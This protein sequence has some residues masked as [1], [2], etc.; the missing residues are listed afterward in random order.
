MT[1]VQYLNFV[2]SEDASMQSTQQIMS[3]SDHTII[4]LSNAA[5]HQQVC[6]NERRPGCQHN[7]DLLDL[8][9]MKC[10]VKSKQYFETFRAN[11]D[12][13][14]WCMA[15]MELHILMKHLIDLVRKPNEIRA[16]ASSLFYSLGSGG[17][18][19]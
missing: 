8:V 6:V 7:R 3:S 18:K 16:T 9:A 14:S 11:I 19:F 1:S 4:A 15:E 13:L 12:A 17:R 5:I 2:I 10:T